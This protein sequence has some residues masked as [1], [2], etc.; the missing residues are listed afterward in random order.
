MKRTFWLL[1]ASG[2]L[3]SC[4]PD[5]KATESDR[6]YLRATGP[7]QARLK[8]FTYSAAY[9]D[10]PDFVTLD[11]PGRLDTLCRTDNLEAV[12]LRGDTVR[13]A[14]DGA[15]RLY[16]K[17]IAVPRHVAGHPVV[18]DTTGH[19][20]ALRP[21]RTYFKMDSQSGVLRPLR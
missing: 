4:V 11:T 1:L 8:W 15:P 14:F 12:N 6:L 7:A 20:P 16:M 10:S 18:V 13:L 2:T 5:F 19:Y 21:Q 9:A 3:T 17:R